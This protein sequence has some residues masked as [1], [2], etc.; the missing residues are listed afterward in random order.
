MAALQPSTR[1]KADVLAIVR[2]IPAGRVATHG[3]I[4]RH[5]AV[6]PRHI[7]TVLITLDAADRAATPWWR[8]VADGGAIGRHALRDDQMARLRVDG[9]VLSPVGI[10]QDLDVR[11]VASLTAQRSG[12]SHQPE[13]ALPTAPLSRSRG[14]KGKPTS[15]V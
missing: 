14:I 13:P 10:V 15:T 9:V 5:L 8:V 4:G 12:M 3:Q 1:I 6:I 11:R 2:R 7:A